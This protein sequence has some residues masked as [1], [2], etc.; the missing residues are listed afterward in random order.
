LIPSV[1]RSGQW[2]TRSGHI[3]KRFDDRIAKRPMFPKII[4]LAPL[5]GFLRPCTAKEVE[6]QLRSCCSDWLKGLRAVFILSGTK[7]QLKS[8]RSSTAFCGRYWRCCVFLHAFPFG[9]ADLNWVHRFYLRDVL[10]HEIGHHVDSRN[11]TR[12]DR[13]QFAQRFARTHG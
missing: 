3:P 6:I 13:E 8:W 10:M 2:M 9:R 1:K 11:T 7:K 4:E 12:K 5:D